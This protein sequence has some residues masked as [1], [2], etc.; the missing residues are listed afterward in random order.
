[1]H[2]AQ[3]IRNDLSSVKICRRPGR[4]IFLS[5]TRDKKKR[6]REKETLARRSRRYGR[7]K[8]FSGDARE[9]ERGE[10]Q[11]NGGDDELRASERAEKREGARTRGRN[12]RREEK[13]AREKM[14]KKYIG[15]TRNEKGKNARSL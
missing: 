10:K 15:N 13:N 4:N 11:A 8:S 3:R 2:D 1:M 12:R 6:K 9:R 14:R 5:C 7:E